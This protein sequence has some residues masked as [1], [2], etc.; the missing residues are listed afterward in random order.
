[1]AEKIARRNAYPFRK[2]A[3]SSYCQSL[4]KLVGKYWRPHSPSNGTE[5]LSRVGAITYYISMHYTIHRTDDLDLPDADWERPQWQAAE[6]LEITHFSWEDSGHRPHTQVRLLYDERALSIIFRV[7]DRYVRAVAERFQDSVCTD[8]CVEFFVSP[9]PDSQAYFNFEVNCGGTML[10]HRCPSAAERAQGR[11]TENVS[12]A[13]GATIRIATTL[14]KIVEP[15]LT[16]PTTWAVE[17]CV[18]FALFAQYFGTQTP[19]PGTQWQGNFYK[20]GDRTSPSPLGF[21]GTR[22]YTQPQLSPARLLSAAR[23]CLALAPHVGDIG[24]DEL[25]IRLCGP[26]YRCLSQKEGNYRRAGGQS[27]SAQGAS[28]PEPPVPNAPEGTDLLPQ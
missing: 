28:E 1:M 10:L 23:I 19:V 26:W 5:P 24:T 7:E 12:D 16:T 4:H 21:V 27:A 9:L 8:S 13:D 20:C 3:T 2:K 14:P 25:K 18:P 17:Y 15:E 11:E 6:T 22:G